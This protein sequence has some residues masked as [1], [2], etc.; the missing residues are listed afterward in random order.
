MEALLGRAFVAPASVPVIASPSHGGISEAI[1]P[2][3][4]Q[5]K[6]R[7]DCTTS[8]NGFIA[9][10]HKF[11]ANGNGYPTNSIGFGVSRQYEL[12]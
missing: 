3:K 6:A 12:T 4:T 1:Q 10:L 7:V 9:V 11:L 5:N 8:K 2:Q